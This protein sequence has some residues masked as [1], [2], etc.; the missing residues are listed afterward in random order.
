M[1][2]FVIA[3]ISRARLEIE[4]QTEKL[5]AQVTSEMAS[6]QYEEQMETLE[7]EKR[8]IMEENENLKK[9]KDDLYEM[10]NSLKKEKQELNNKLEQFIQEN[11]EL[12]DKLEKLSAEKVS[13]AESIEI[14]E[15]LTQQEKLELEAYQKKLDFVAGDLKVSEENLPQADLNESVNELTEE[16]S[17][18]L[19]KIELFTVERREVMEKMEQLKQEN[20]ALILKIKEIEN[21]RDILAE[22]YEHL[23]SEKEVLVEKIGNLE[24]ENL[25][26]YEKCKHNQQSEA[27]HLQLFEEINKNKELYDK[28]TALINENGLLKEKL[29]SDNETSRAKIQELERQLAQIKNDSDER[30]IEMQTRLEN[31]QQK[32]INYNEIEEELNRLKELENELEENKVSIQE[33]RTE[34]YRIFNELEEHKREIGQLNNTLKDKTKSLADMENENK[35]LQNKIEQLEEDR[36]NF[37]QQI[38]KY[39]EELE[40]VNNAEWKNRRLLESKENEITKFMKERD[41][42]ANVILD[43]QKTLQDKDEKFHKMSADL[44]NKYVALQQKLEENSGSITNLTEPLEAKIEELTAKNK[45]QLDKMKKIAANFKKKSQA[46]QELEKQFKKAKESYDAELKLNLQQLQDLENKLEHLQKEH[47]DKLEEIRNLNQNNVDLQNII[48]DLKVKIDKS[49]EVSLQKELLLT[50]E[51]LGSV[52]NS[53]QN[54]I[55]EL[56]MI[57][58]TQDIELNKSRARVNKLEEGI[59]YMEERR[60]SLERKAIEL[61]A[62]LEQKSVSFDEMTKSEDLLERRLIALTEHDEAIERKLE[63]AIIENQKMRE[64]LTNSDKEFVKLKRKLE[65][66]L[67]QYNE[68]NE[69]KTFAEER[70]VE[71]GDIKKENNNLQSEL[72]TL[73]QEYGRCLEEHKEDIE[74]INADWEIQFLE[75][76]KEK[77]EI[78]MQC[79]KFSEELKEITEKEFD[80]N[81]ELLDYKVKLEN[82]QAEI[83]NYQEQMQKLLVE[84]DALNCLKAEI[85]EK[86]KTITSLQEQQRESKDFKEETPVLASFFLNDSSQEQ[87]K[88]ENN[89]VD[90]LRQVIISKDLEIQNILE[91]KNHI[92]E[93]VKYLQKAFADSQQIIE[94]LEQ[95][96]RDTEIKKTAEATVD[97]VI[98]EAGER[99]SPQKTIPTFTWSKEENDPFDFVQQSEVLME[100]SIPISS[101]TNN[102]QELLDKIKTLEYVLY[103][104]EKEKDEAVLQCHELSNELAHL[105]YQREKMS[106]VESQIL[107]ESDVKDSADTSK[108]LQA[109]EFEQTSFPQV[110]SLEGGPILEDIV[111]SKE[112]Y[113]C[114]DD[115]KNSQISKV[116]NQILSETDIVDTADTRRE[117]QDIEFTPVQ[118]NPTQE[119]QCT[120]REAYL[121]FNEND[122]GWSWGP[123]E[124]KLE[125]EHAKKLELTDTLQNKIRV[126]ELER[127][128]HLEE[129]RQLQ[130]K[131]GKLIKKLKEFKIKNEQLKQKSEGGI[132]DAFNLDDA[133]QE[134]LKLQIQQVEKKLKET[135]S[136]LEKERNE[137]AAILKRVDVLTTANDRLVEMKEK[138]DIEL[139]GWQ[140][141]CRELSSKLE[142]FEWGDDGFVNTEQS[143][144]VENIDKEKDTQVLS[145][146][147][148][149]LNET[150]KD[151]TLDNEEMQTLLEEQRRLRIEAE[152]ALNSISQLTKSEEE[153]ND[154]Q[155]QL[156]ATLLE[157]NNLQ[158]QFQ[159]IAQVQNELETKLQVCLNERDQIKN[160]LVL[161]IQ[162]KNTLQSEF[163][164]LFEEQRNAQNEMNINAENTKSLQNQVNDYIK[165][166]NELLGRLQALENQN[167]ELS[168]L[169][170]SKDELLEHARN[171]LKLAEQERDTFVADLQNKNMSIDSLKGSIDEQITALKGDLESQTN[172]AKSLLEENKLLTENASQ[173]DNEIT[174]LT[175][176]IN[177]MVEEWE[178]RVDQ[179]GSDV[180][181]SWKLHLESREN[182]FNEID[183][184]LRKEIKDLEEKNNTLVNENSALRNNVNAEINTEIDK[185]SVLQQ[186]ITDSEQNIYELSVQLKKRESEIQA[187]QSELNILRQDKLL[188]DEVL[189][190]AHEDFGK[191]LT[192]EEGSLPKFLKEKQNEIIILQRELE[193][194][195]NKDSIQLQKLNTLLAESENTS[196]SL[197]SQVAEVH[198]L[199]GLLQER[200]YFVNSQTLEIEKVNLLLQEKDQLLEQTVKQLNEVE[201]N[202]EELQ[203]SLQNHHHQIQDRSNLLEAREH[204]L[205]VLKLAL[206]EKQREQTYAIGNISQEYQSSMQ[207][208]I[209]EINNLKR[210]LLDN[211]NHYEELLQAKDAELEELQL[212]LSQQLQAKIEEIENLVV[213]YNAKCDEIVNLQNKIEEQNIILDEDSKQLNELKEII[214]EQVLKIEELKKDL[215]EKSS[216]YD[217]LIAEMDLG[218]SALRQEARSQ[219]DDDLTD[220][221]SRAELDLALYMLHQRDVRCEELTVELTQLLEER[222]TLQLRLSNALREREEIVRNLKL[223]EESEADSSL[224]SSNLLMPEP[225][226]VALDPLSSK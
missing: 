193:E 119:E 69:R 44:K 167:K 76:V 22:T 168:A 14:V 217:S 189:R 107:Q 198:M 7:G 226:E 165:T 171:D 142:K 70:L 95:T 25:E 164:S 50:T 204:E 89:E 143:S 5:N 43:L 162:E 12:M 20:N 74:K 16:T 118:V 37:N 134:E 53:L 9:E 109:L 120:S 98:S 148:Q 184:L 156:D 57:V 161:T 86:E 186:Q 85:E 42:T 2:L 211:E 30:L 222:D 40:S 206:E 54:K 155:Q 92:N 154:L 121:C 124:A 81:K 56:E 82:S 55:Q 47:D 170:A 138:Q 102:Q 224:N 79:E 181:E 58:E 129:I 31:L 45:E 213:Q 112:A 32:I 114:F 122:D 26:L 135:G 60:L 139:I 51:N 28:L 182:E 91:E 137:K 104:V 140:Q 191:M 128:N 127:E 126:L 71:Y 90:N 151:L 61:G 150:I 205:S 68:V 146:E 38:D 34:F 188:L 52:E 220:P 173:K 201:H 117:L 10:I 87:I 97:T 225:A 19:Q 223:S 64:Q 152:K 147:I 207:N 197:E 214:E 149:E 163:D 62:E 29:D 73:R 178:L 209:E 11:M 77:T 195:Q 108:E 180:A 72:K 210:R 208:Q 106:S 3:E 133:I 221:A 125:E 145:K 166:H 190:V 202:N 8:S 83:I 110:S 67:T 80:F 196:T 132:Q 192:R 123:E 200:D 1:Y 4:T 27:T 194:L 179:R 46:Y 199:R 176:T 157:H 183:Q 216:D 169:V 75:I 172:T 131:S 39:Q 103:N 203:K 18:L 141:N 66:V 136:D 96:I 93:T 94:N 215:Y 41:N 99:I 153:K 13:S 185:I 187:C 100:P 219:V 111:Q 113:I 177:Q 84:N 63:E 160:Q 59:A 15:N 101:D 24:T 78:M 116:E 218:K 6:I 105:L 130:V 212:Q 33:Q 36:N 144:T 175:T 159:S 49:N 23:Q 65:E 17:E 35:S 48:T 174:K 88:I 21:N 158:T 115:E